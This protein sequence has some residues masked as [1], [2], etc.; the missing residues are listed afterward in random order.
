MKLNQLNNKE[1]E[2]RKPGFFFYCFLNIL[3]VTTIFLKKEKAR[4]SRAKKI[5]LT[6]K[7][8]GKFCQ[9]LFL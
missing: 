7:S 9:Q 3:L 8:K 4:P 1:K 2:S 6:N 5:L